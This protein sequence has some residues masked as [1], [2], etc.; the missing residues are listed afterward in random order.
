ML[1]TLF[2]FLLKMT[3]INSPILKHCCSLIIHFIKFAKS[4]IRESE[5]AYNF[6]N[7][8][9]TM[10]LHGSIFLFLFIKARN[11]ELR[12]II[13]EHLENDYTLEEYIQIKKM[14]TFL[15]ES[16]RTKPIVVNEES[17]EEES[18]KNYNF[19]DPQRLYN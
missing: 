5:E 7:V 13:S 9:Y 11:E 4:L 18:T 1:H 16:L 3:I 17:R 12:E 14:L 6:K 19:K 8:K 10:I 15:Q 2:D